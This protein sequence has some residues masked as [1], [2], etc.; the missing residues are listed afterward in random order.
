MS[1]SI[2]LFFFFGGGGRA[3]PCQAFYQAMNKR[4]CS[5]DPG[6][7]IGDTRDKVSG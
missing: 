5:W 4:T 7:G 1:H 2:G 3:P 6:V